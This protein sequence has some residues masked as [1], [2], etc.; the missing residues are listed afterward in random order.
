MIDL[1]DP[2][3]QVDAQVVDDRPVLAVA[4]VE[5]ELVGRVS[6]SLGTEPDRPDLVLDRSTLSRVDVRTPKQASSAWIS[7]DLSS[8][9]LRSIEP[10]EV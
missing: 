8:A 10:P 1:R 5:V 7:P 3:V 6:F 4:K 9:V 2:S